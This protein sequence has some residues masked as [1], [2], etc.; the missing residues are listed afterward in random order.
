MNDEIGIVMACSLYEEDEITLVTVLTECKVTAGVM[1]VPKE[2]YV[3]VQATHPSDPTMN[4]ELWTVVI[5]KKA[6]Y[7]VFIH[8]GDRSLTTKEQHSFKATVLPESNTLRYKWI[9]LDKLLNTY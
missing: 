3:K 5:P 2:Y 1:Q 8:G 7:T 9:C 4:S 6:T